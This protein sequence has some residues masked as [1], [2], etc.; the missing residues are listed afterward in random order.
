MR[1]KLKL[2]EGEHQLFPI[3]EHLTTRQ[4]D[5]NAIGTRSCGLLGFTRLLVQLSLVEHGSRIAKR[6][7]HNLKIAALRMNGSQSNGGIGFGLRCQ[8]VCIG[9]QILHNTHQRCA[10]GCGKFFIEPHIQH[11]PARLVLLSSCLLG[12]LLIPGGEGHRAQSSCGPLCAVLLRH[13]TLCSTTTLGDVDVSRYC[14]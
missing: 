11:K 13:L 5:Q 14:T 4:I 3:K 10:V 1:Q 12:A 6:I 2:F 9:S 8:M 7:A